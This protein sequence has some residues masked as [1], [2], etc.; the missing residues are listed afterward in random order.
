MR[1]IEAGSTRW[2]QGEPPAV[3]GP[4]QD[5]II[6]LAE[7]GDARFVKI[8]GDHVKAGRINSERANAALRNGH[9]D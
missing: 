5:A 9:A 7:K 2:A 6:E 8:L 4:W 3:R 1:G